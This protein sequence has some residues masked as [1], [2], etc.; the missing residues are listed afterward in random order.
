MS[1]NQPGIGSENLFR[2]L[3]PGWLILL[4]LPLGLWMAW[5]FAFPVYL[6]R[7]RLTV[8]IEADGKIHSGT[9]VIQVEW[10]QQPLTHGVEHIRGE[11]VFVG[12][13]NRGAVLVPLK[14]GAT[15]KVTPNPEPVL[16]RYLATTAYRAELAKFPTYLDQLKNLPRMRGRKVLPEN[17]LPRM[18]WVS[19]VS[20]LDTAVPVAPQNFIKT[21][22]KGVVLQKVWLEITQDPLGG[23]LLQKLP[24]LAA[25]ARDNKTLMW[26]S[27]LTSHDLLGDPQ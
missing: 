7:F 11:A 2:R 13:G 10:Q 20:G 12:L 3:L 16:M 9:S 4:G 17:K 18:I 5:T 21:I 23:G 1:L 8:E 14:W 6:H 27:K 19:D 24:W 22:G 15:Q 25:A 26:P